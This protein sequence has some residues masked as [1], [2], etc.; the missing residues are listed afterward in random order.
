MHIAHKSPEKS[1]RKKRHRE[2]KV[3]SGFLYLV[4]DVEH[5]FQTDV[6]SRSNV[7][8][9]AGKI[10]AKMALNETVPDFKWRSASNVMVDFTAV[11]FLQF[12]IAMD[13]FVE[14]QYQDVWNS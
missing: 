9:R 5:L 11:E 13:E 12:A 2:A 8:G 14:L 10:T 7:T 4:N 1:E 6:L 3:S